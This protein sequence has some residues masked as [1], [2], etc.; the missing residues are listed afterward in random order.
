MVDEDY[1][2][3]ES[4]SILTQLK[5]FDLVSSLPLDHMHLVSL[6]VMKKLLLLWK[7]GP[8]KTRLRSKDIKDLSKSLLTLNTDIA[9]DFVRKSRSLFEVSRWKAVE[10]RFFFAIFRTNCFK[11]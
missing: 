6:G 9:S 2:T 5:N 1:H 4:L 10:L 8:L 11:I 7:S 3:S